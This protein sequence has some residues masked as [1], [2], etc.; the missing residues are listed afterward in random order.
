M[1]QPY[2]YSLNVPNPAQALTQGLQTGV[3]LG[4]VQAQAQLRNQQAQALQAKAQ[5][6]QQFQQVLGGLGGNPS[7]KQLSGVLTQ[8]PE[9]SGLL[10]ESYDRLSTGEQKERTSQ[11]SSVYAAVLAGDTN[12]AKQQLSEY[13]TAYRNAGREDDAKALEA[14]AKL[15]ELHP[16][17]AE[18]GISL[19]LAEN[20]GPE[21]FADTF[22]EL[23]DQRRATSKEGVE[24]TKAEADAKTAAVKAGF[25]ESDA[26]ADLQKKGWDISKIQNDIAVSRQNSRIAAMTAMAAKEGNQLK[27][28]ELQLKIDE[29]KEKRDTTVRTRAADVE[30]ARATTD[31]LLSSIDDLFKVPLGYLQNVT[32]P[33]DSKTPT[34]STESAKV[35]KLLENIQNQVAL[36]NLDKLKG[37]TSDRDLVFLKAAI[38]SL[39]PA[40][41][42]ESLLKNAREVQRIMLKTRAN[43]TTK[44]GVPETTPDTPSAALDPNSD[45]VNALVSGATGQR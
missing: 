8:F 35:E 32:G 40:Q 4:E 15:I 39:D 31:N 41:G 24:L 7:A 10:K 1:P 37:P 14:K 44:Y 22:G 23:Q 27:R 30:A 38:R 19:W 28:E 11:A 9:M 26:A 34:L 36:G 45:D 20:M 13:A 3:E 6:Q 12:L 29:A 42:A 18:R 16:E 21:K 5:R 43:L 17:A 2:N 33:I 25:A